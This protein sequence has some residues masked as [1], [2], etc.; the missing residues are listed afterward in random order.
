MNVPAGTDTQ[1]RL[2]QRAARPSHYRELS[3]KALLFYSFALAYELISQF[4]QISSKAGAV[5]CMMTPSNRSASRPP[6]RVVSISDP[7]N[8]INTRWKKYEAATRIPLALARHIPPL[9]GHPDRSRFSGGGKDLARTHAVHAEPDP[10]RILTRLNCAGFGMTPPKKPTASAPAFSPPFSTPGTTA[11]TFSL[12]G[13]SLTFVA[14][15][16]K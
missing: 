7:R 10:H 12:C 9:G 8:E 3:G 11:V 14:P 1:P 4:R 15:R 16:W 5:H 2:A 13:L 6:K